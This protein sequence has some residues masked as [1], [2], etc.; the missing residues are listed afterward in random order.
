MSHS[1]HPPTW[2]L[3]VLFS[4][5]RTYLCHYV[6]VQILCHFYLPCPINLHGKRLIEIDNNA[7]MPILHSQT[8]ETAVSNLFGVFSLGVEKI[9]LHLKCFGQKKYPIIFST[10]VSKIPLMQYLGFYQNIP[11]SKCIGDEV[12]CRPCSVT[13]PGLNVL[14][15]MNMSKYSGVWELRWGGPVGSCIYCMCVCIQNLLL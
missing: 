1:L 5:Y 9:S 2:F 11:W 6:C 4:R 14:L 8:T 13:G 15:L 12:F 7:I 10:T 3:C